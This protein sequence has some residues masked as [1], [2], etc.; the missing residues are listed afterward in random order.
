MTYSFFPY[1][2]NTSDAIQQLAVSTAR[3]LYM[4]IL[5]SSNCH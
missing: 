3:Q 1:N 4:Y 5:K 2:N